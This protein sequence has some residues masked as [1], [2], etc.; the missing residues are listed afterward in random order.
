MKIFKKAIA[1]MTALFTVAGS[2]CL[3]VSVAASDTA[4]VVSSGRAVVGN[5]TPG[6]AVVASYGAGG[7]LTKVVKQP[8]K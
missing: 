1:A 8:V 5:G 2:L 4:I 7:K 3:P 6:I